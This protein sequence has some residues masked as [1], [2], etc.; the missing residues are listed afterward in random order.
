MSVRR[1]VGA[2]AVLF[3]FSVA[4]VTPE[5]SKLFVPF[6]DPESGVT[7]Y[8]LRPGLLGE[9]QQSIYFT[10]KSMTD[11]GRFLLLDVS[12]DEKVPREKRAYRGK[13]KALVDFEKDEAFV[14]PDI[15]GRIP[16]IDEK[17]DRIYYFRIGPQGDH[18]RDAL[19]RRDLLV[20]PRRE[21]K[22]CD[23]PRELTTGVTNFN[24]YSTHPTLTH[25]RKRL[26]IG[27]SIN[28]RF[29]Q[30]CIRLDTGGWES[31]GL[32]DFHANHDQINP[33][34]DRLAMVAW[35]FCWTGAGKKYRERTGWYPRM[36]LA[37]P[38]GRRELIPAREKNMASHECW[39]DDGKGLCWCGHGVWHM[40]LATRRQV[41]VATLDNARHATMSPDLKYAVFDVEVDR[42]WRGCPWRVCFVNRET[43]R[44]VW[45]YTKSAALRPRDSESGLHPDPHPQFVCRGRYIVCTYNTPDSRMA[46]CVTPVAQLVARTSSAAR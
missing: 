45:I 9:N 35:E 30:G 40:D 6:T 34:N 29:G 8:L 42:W 11:D 32:S 44:T 10:A 18:T 37:Y 26:F 21:I 5:T 24:A 14:L 27:W 13:R 19:C 31:W 12:C 28:G 43:D 33:V 38:D 15:D 3:G 2:C 41:C 1:F 17:E 22:V 25:D 7:S 39:D 23:M 16:C 36:W 46:V 4:A 20:D